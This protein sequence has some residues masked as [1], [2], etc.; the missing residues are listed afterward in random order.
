MPKMRLGWYAGVS[1]SCLQLAPKGG[2]SSGTTINIS[3]LG[4]DGPC[5]R[6]RLLGFS[7]EGQLL[8][9]NGISVAEQFLLACEYSRG[10]ACLA[11]IV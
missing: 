10:V 4:V 1:S 6:R 9:G 3:F 8:L 7:T 11:L 5:W 2:P